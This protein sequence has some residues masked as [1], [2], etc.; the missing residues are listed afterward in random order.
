MQMLSVI[1]I[2]ENE[3]VFMFCFRFLKVRLKMP[4]IIGV[5]LDRRK[6]STT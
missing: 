4:H 5:K 1:I 3:S 2:L 6:Y